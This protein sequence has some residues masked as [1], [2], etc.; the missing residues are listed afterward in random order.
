MAVVSVA[1]GIASTTLSG[2]APVPPFGRLEAR[3][4]VAAA[5][6]A[7]LTGIAM[8][9]DVPGSNRRFSRL[10]AADD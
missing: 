2:G 7:L 8:G 10:A 3:L 9:V 4:V 1:A 5:I 6:M